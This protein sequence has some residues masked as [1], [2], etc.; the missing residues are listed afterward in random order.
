[1]TRAMPHLGGIRASRA[2]TL[3]VTDGLH[4]VTAYVRNLAGG[5]TALTDNILLDTTPPGATVHALAPYYNT[6]AF[7]VSWSGADAGTGLANFDV[8]ARDGGGP[9]TDWLTSTAAL[10]ATFAGLDGHTLYFRARG[11]DTVGN[12]GDYAL[13]NGD[14]STFVDSRRP[15]GDVTINGGA[16]DT[17]S[18]TVVLALNSADA[19]QMAF[20]DDGTGFSASEPFA[21]A[22]SYHL[23][24]ADGL[25]TVY[26]RFQNLVGNTS[27]YSDTINLDTSVPGDVGFSINNDDPITDQITVTLTLKAPPGMSHMMVSNSNPL[28]QG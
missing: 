14:T 10:S 16:I 15:G 5:V 17:I 3:P 25:K 20:S 6:L 21:A 12:V 23:P 27:T 1:M 22:R 26:V 18:S 9:W 28:C 7:T 19:T 4:L 24:G 8:Q 11:R 2:W 13:G